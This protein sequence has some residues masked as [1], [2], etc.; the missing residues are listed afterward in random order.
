MKRLLIGLLATA[1]SDPRGEPESSPSPQRRVIAPPSGTLRALPP[2]AIVP[3]GVGPYKLR[4]PVAPLL[5]KLKSGPLSVRFEI[6]NILHSA[7]SRAEDGTLLIGSELSAGTATAMTFIAVI[8]SEVARLDSGLRVGSSKE[9]AQKFGVVTDDVERAQDP[10]MLVP[11]AVRNARLVI[12]KKRVAAIVLAGEPLVPAPVGPREKDDCPRPAST[13][14]AFG[15]CLTGT[16]ELVER[17][18]DD[19]VVHFPDAEKPIARIPVPNLVFAAPLRN[20]ADGHDELIAITRTTDESN[21]RT[22]MLVAFRYD[23]GQLKRAIELWPQPLY[24]LTSTQ[25]RW[26]GAELRDVDLYLEL[27]SRPEG[28]EVG[29]LLTTSRSERIHDVVTISPVM[30]PRKHAKPATPEA[31]DAGAPGAE[32]AASGLGSASR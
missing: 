16:G 24:Q 30:V 21:Q 27:T 25:T 9:E 5:D 2:Y 28:I 26:I 31:V 19:L 18:G 13:A 32:A 15:I 3:E 11:T 4:E 8:G 6:P 14:T 10:R 20:V 17:D 7:Q 29:G 1:C 23:G 12:D 22:W